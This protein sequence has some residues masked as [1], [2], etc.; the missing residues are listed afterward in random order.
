MST[1][2]K[3]KCAQCLVIFGLILAN[4]AYLLFSPLFPG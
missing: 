2:T 3:R 1:E 4:A